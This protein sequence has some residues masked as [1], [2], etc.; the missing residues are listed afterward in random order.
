MLESESHH[1]K[2]DIK[3]VQV[4]WTAPT[5]AQQAPKARRPQLSPKTT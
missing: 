3:A 2:S 4:K 5:Q 1:F